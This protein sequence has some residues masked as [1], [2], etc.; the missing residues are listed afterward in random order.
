MTYPVRDWSRWYIPQNHGDQTDYG[1]HD[2]A[3]INLKTGGNTD[4]GEDLLAVADGEITGIHL[5]GYSSSPT[6]GNHLFLKIEGEWGLVWVHYAHCKDV[7]VKEGDK[8][9][10]GRVIATLGATGRPKG[11][12]LAH[13]HFSIKRNANGMD[14]VPNTLEEL[15]D[16][17]DP[18]AFLNKWIPLTSEPVKEDM[19]L[20]ELLTYYNVKDID[21]LKTMVDKELGFLKSEREKNTLLNDQI[22]ELKKQETKL[23]DDLARTNEELSYS[24]KQ[25]ES[26]KKKYEQDLSSIS[27]LKQDQKDLDNSLKSLGITISRNSGGVLEAHK[28]SYTVND[29]I[30]GIIYLLRRKEA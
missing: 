6:F 14:N 18:I 22:T 3:D 13:L 29:V 12:M 28:Q 26:E 24:I 30:S 10:E 15:K 17:I 11:K 2:G 25:L 16:W 21:E 23:L 7:F 4:E 8:V 27:Q 9:K 19:N 5:H 20:N 1:W